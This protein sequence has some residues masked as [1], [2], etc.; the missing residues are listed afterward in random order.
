M[1]TTQHIP[2]LIKLLL[3]LLK[4]FMNLVIYC[5]YVFFVILT[6]NDFDRRRKIT[7]C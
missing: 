1:S 5:G 7:T 2:L 4:E 6:S 3:M